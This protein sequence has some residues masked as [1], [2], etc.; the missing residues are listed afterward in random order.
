MGKQPLHLEGEIIFCLHGIPSFLG[1]IFGH[2]LVSRGSLYTWTHTPGLAYQEETGDRPAMVVAEPGVVR[3]GMDDFS[4]G[5][6][7][8]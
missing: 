3:G 6:G 2:P 7:L 4:V 8:L 1:R 5:D